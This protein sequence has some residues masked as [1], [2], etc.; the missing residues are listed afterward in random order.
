MCFFFVV[1]F[2]F[3]VV[4]RVFARDD[5]LSFLFNR[6]LTQITIPRQLQ[7]LKHYLRSHYADN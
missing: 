4:A 1:V 2:F 5:E 3:Q 6:A 7:I